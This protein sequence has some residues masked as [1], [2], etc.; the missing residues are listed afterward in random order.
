MSDTPL[1][2]RSAALAFS[3]GRL[4]RRSEHRPDGIIKT[5]LADPDAKLILF[6]G[7]RLVTGA[8]TS[9]PRHLFSAAERLHDPAGAV[10][11]GETED[12]TPVLAA[13]AAFEAETPPDG[14][15]ATDLRGLI[16]RE[17]LAG[18]A[19]GDIAHAASLMAWHRANPHCARCGGL[20]A[21][22]AGG[23]KR[24]CETCGAEAFPRTDP[25]AIMLVTRGDMCL[26]GRSPH[27]PPGMVS[28]L[29]GFIEQGETVED[30]VRRETFEESGIR[31][32][33]VTYVASQPWPMP[34]SLM[35]GFACEALTETIRHDETEL[36]LCRW[37]PRADVRAMLAGEQADG[38]TA[39]MKGA[40]ARE[41]MAMFAAG[42]T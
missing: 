41:L 19:L 20:T 15:A 5:A 2:E 18:P 26:L 4:D 37:F 16:A 42:E 17:A 34:H 14:L 35:L 38:F 28:C 21:M 39:P 3:G 9:A 13:R 23:A 8:E 7:N 24:V 12:G 10:Y 1:F 36:D 33:R 25:V 11:L 31:V 6:A 27:F 40:I 32:G 29:A 30:A 22:A